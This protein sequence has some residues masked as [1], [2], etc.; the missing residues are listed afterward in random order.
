MKMCVDMKEWQTIV[1]ERVFIQDQ[2]E[3]AQFQRET[4]RGMSLTF[5]ECE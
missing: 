5:N 4:G 2:Q 1:G 3:Y